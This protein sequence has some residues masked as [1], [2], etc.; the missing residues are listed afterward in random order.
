MCHATYA[1]TDS[2][3]GLTGTQSVA[4]SCRFSREHSPL[5]S[6]AAGHGSSVPIAQQW[7]CIEGRE[8]TNSFLRFLCS[9]ISS[10]I[11]LMCPPTRRS[12]LSR[13]TRTMLVTS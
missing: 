6:V 1:R 8:D 12:E 3:R 11:S 7:P 4:F 9:R 10:K 13:L 5:P 2:T